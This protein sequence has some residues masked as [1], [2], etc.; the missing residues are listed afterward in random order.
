MCSQGG[1]RTQQI[2]KLERG[3]INGPL[4]CFG[5]HA[6]CSSEFCRTAQNKQ[7]SQADIVLV[8]EMTMREMIKDWKTSQSQYTVSPYLKKKAYFFIIRFQPHP[9]LVTF[10]Y[11]VLEEVIKLE[12]KVVC[13]KVTIQ[14]KIQCKV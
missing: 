5:Y 7:Q 10:P 9:I 14:Y 2:K 4:H 1:D 11:K 8:E 6:K 3:L 13:D 12:Q